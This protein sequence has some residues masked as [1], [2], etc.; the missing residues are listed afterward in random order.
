MRRG[1]Q[2]G[3]RA[4]RIE[5]DLETIDLLANIG[6]KPRFSYNP[7]NRTG[8]HFCDISDR[9]GIRAH[10][11]GWRLEFDLPKTLCEL[12]QRRPGLGA[13]NHVAVE[14]NKVADGLRLQGMKRL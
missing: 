12:I 5:F 10:S 6:H 7:A 2:P 8:N 13:A 1:I 4:A 9:T 14:S 3:R 11:P